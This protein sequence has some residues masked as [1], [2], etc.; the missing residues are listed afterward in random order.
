MV[1]EATD[2]PRL[3]GVDFEFVADFMTCMADPFFR[4]DL[5]DIP[6]L[7]PRHTKRHTTIRLNVKK[8][9]L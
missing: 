2:V 3:M 6:Y 8:S 1:A 5:C 7:S 4:H 9:F